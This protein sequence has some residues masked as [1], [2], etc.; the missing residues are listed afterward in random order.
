VTA[1]LLEKGGVVRL[2]ET[3]THLV[4]EALGTKPSGL[5]P[6]EAFRRLQ[7]FGPNLLPDPPRPSLVRRL[8]GNFTHLMA[9]LLWAG[10]LIAFVAELPQLGAAILIVNLI[11]GLFS[12]W[13]EYKAEKATEALR[14]LLPTR[15]SVLR[16][17]IEAQVGAEDLVPGDLVLLS[18]G[19]RISA[20]AR[21][22]EAI[23]LRVDQSTLTGES[24]PVRKSAEPFESD[25]RSPAELPSLV[26]AGT[27]VT[28]GRGRAVVCATGMDT[29]FGKV[30]ALTGGMK[31]EL[32]PLQVEMKRVSVIV[33]A[34]AVAAGLSFF[35]LA[36]TVGEVPLARGFVFALGMI[37]AFVPEGL[38]PTVT[39]A[40]ALGTQRMAGRNA[41]V[42]R[43]SAVETLGSTTVICTDKTGTLTQN[44][45]TVRAAAVGPSIFQ[46]TGV[47][48]APAGSVSPGPDRGLLELLGAAVLSSNA[49]LVNPASAGAR[50]SVVGDPTEGALLVAAMKAGIDLED[51]TARAPRLAE[52]PF[53]AVRKR[54]SAL[55]RIGAE[56][57]LSVK[58]A[59]AE[60]LARCS[61]R[62]DGGALDEA[63]RQRVMADVERFASE[64]LRVLAAA[65]RRLETVDTSA[66]ADTVERDL[67]FL[68]LLAMHDPPRPE[69]EAAVGT[70]QRA[71]IRIV[72][73]TGDYGVTAVTIGQR[74]GVVSSEG[75]RIIN[76]DE[77]D[78][79]G[80]VELA[81]A[82][83]TEVVFARATPEHKL[84]I[85]TALQARGEVVAVTGD[86]VNDAPA[87]MKADI[88]VAMGLSGTDV[89]KEAA[90]MILLD[91]NFASI[92]A[93]VEEGRAVYSNIRKFTTYVLTSNA[94][95]AVPF[96]TFA[97]SGGT[98]P[99]ALGVMHILAIDLGTDLAPALGLGAE[100]PE[101]GVMDK[102]PR[103]RAEHVIDRRLLARAYLWLGAIQAGFVMLSFFLTF[104]L[105]GY[106]TTDGLPT[107]GANY[108]A[109][110]AVALAAVVFTQIGNLFAQRSETDSLLSV[111]FGGNRL[112][113][114]GIGSELVLIG[115]IV[116][117]PA[118]AGI[119]G[120]AP[121]PPIAWLWLLTGIPLLPLADEAR[122]ALVRRPSR[123]NL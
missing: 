96:V 78:R 123:R 103:A 59:P 37:V 116:Y 55:N 119:I 12:F 1:G 94:P 113:W 47:G 15:V 100:P 6:T 5:D 121:F 76:G 91:D 19:D 34:V 11:N 44:E 14:S 117:V 87:L 43:L 90:D 118:L 93:A 64:G 102:P 26:M 111:G 70:C 69:V 74:I 52:F 10:G 71:G 89:A 101:P 95:E 65:R 28:G 2:A 30:A 112:L 75:T 42:K 110:T 33:S 39:L 46:F 56:A 62:E 60:L 84:R 68:G 50:W 25:G 53:D 72:M 98:I 45:M 23:A 63:F 114:W 4:F 29:E 21:L 106:Q 79:M 38:L 57:V 120:T 31:E 48:Y 9:L 82:L 107:S 86:G 92:V 81:R 41:L 105:L 16:A 24:R 22:V 83:E 66:E 80:E 13:Q 8:V 54:M 122:K 32:S 85:V 99:L 104:R 88:G 77:L 17:G 109:A 18:E 108:R 35:V 67:E 49:R 97:L 20:D 7:S 73:I 51:L 58:G 36:L 27:T 3:Q 115:L 61:R 40:L